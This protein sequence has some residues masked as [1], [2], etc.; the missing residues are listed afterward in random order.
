MNQIAQKLNECH[1][2]IEGIIGEMCEQLTV[3]PAETTII[4]IEGQG[5]IAIILHDLRDLLRSSVKEINKVRE[6]AEEQLCRAIADSGEIPYRHPQ[7]TIIPAAKGFF[8]IKDARLFFNWLE[9]NSELQ[10]EGAETPL[11]TF[12]SLTS[13]KKSCNAYFEELLKRGEPLPE[14]VNKHIIAT[15]QIRRRQSHG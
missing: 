12:L 9:R 10:S 1:A 4:D 5:D 2:Q 6:K 13:S 8:G 14:G 3:I 7:A 15:V 11:D